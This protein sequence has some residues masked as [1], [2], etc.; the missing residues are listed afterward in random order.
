MKK[1]VAL[2]MAVILVFSLSVVVSAAK[3][4]S[5]TGKGKYNV[6]VI[7]DG[8]SK[9][10]QK[11]SVTEGEGTITATADTTKGT[12]NKW[13]VYKMNGKTAV[14]AVIGTDYVI[15]SGS[16][17]DPEIV[18]EPLND[19]IIAANFDDEI[20]DV[21]AWLVSEDSPK[22]GDAAML[23]VAIF[24]VIAVA[25]VFASRKQLG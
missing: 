7:S 25:G 10:G 21:S 18:I 16:L 19:V 22:T 2:L 3:V 14:E 20:T 24:A 4:Y 6:V 8:N 17:I 23:F 12:F 13:T 5:P 1:L 9:N 15:I 11:Y